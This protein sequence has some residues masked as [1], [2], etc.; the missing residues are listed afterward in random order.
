MPLKKIDENPTITDTVVFEITTPDA[1]GCLLA[2]PYKVESLVIY[3]V[4]RDFSSGNLSEY[5]NR[6][7]DAAK[8]KAAEDAEKKACADPTQANIDEAKRLRAESEASKFTNSFYFNEAKPVQVIGSKLFPAWLSTDTG[9][10]YITYVDKDANGVTQY[11]HFR[12][13]WQPKGVREG[14]YF[15]CW[16]WTPNP[17][18]DSLSAHLRFTLAGN[19][20]V[21]TSIPTHFTPPTKYETLLERYTPEM[22]K[23][24]MCHDDRTPD[25]L[26]KFNKSVAAGFTSLEDLA[27]QIVDLQD[28][29]SLHEALIPYLSNFFDLKLKTHDPTL[30]RRQ[31]KRAIPLFK[32]KGT[33]PALEEAMAQ[34]GLSLKKI[35]ML[36]QVVSPYTWQESFTFDTSYFFDLAKV[37]LP[38]DYLNFGLW[39]RMKGETDYISLSADYVNFT[40]SGGVTRMTWVGH[41]LSVQAIDLEKGDI[42]RVLYKYK[43][44]PSQTEQTIENYIRSLPLADIRDETAQ[45]Y[46]LKNWNVRL[47]EE[48]DPLFDLVIPNRHPYTDPLVFGK[49]RTEFPYSENV[50]NMDE[51]NGSIR[52]S[53]LPCDIGKE[54]LDPCGACMS[55]KFN[56]DVEIENLSNDRIKEAQEVIKEFVPFHAVLHTMN[57]TGSMNEFVQPPVEEIEML[58][59]YNGTDYAIV[60]E[61]QQ[62]FNRSMIL[63]LTSQQV[64]RNALATSEVAVATTTGTAYNDNIVVFSPDVN[65]DDIGLPTDG[66]GILEILP[67]SLIAGTTTLSNPKGHT[68]VV[69]AA[70]E[71]IA[72]CASTT[73]NN[74][75]FTFRVSNEVL[76]G[77]T[78]CNITQ[79]DLFTFSDPAVDFT[80]YA[81]KSEWDVARGTATAP[82]K[83]Q[84][85]AY[86]PTPYPIVHVL[87][88]GSLVLKNNGT[89]PTYAV[90]NVDYMLQN[91][92]GT[93]MKISE[94]GRLAVT[95]RAKTKA[96]SITMQD[97]AEAIEIGYYQVVGSSQYKV[98]GF[99]EGT[100]DS[101]Y[102]ADWTSGDSA[103]VAL[104]VYQRL[105]DNQVGY[106][107]HRGLKLRASGN[108]ES[109]LSIPN[110]KN[111][112]IPE[113]SITEN[114][115]FKENFLIVIDVTPD[116]DHVYFMAEI[117]GGNPPGF[118]T[119]TLDGP[120][121]YWKTLAAGGTTV[122]FTIYRY[123]KTANI[124][125]PGQQ[126]DL[127]A[128]TFKD[129]DRQGREIITKTITT[130]SSM[131]GGP[132]MGMA[133]V[134]EG[135]SIF[136]SIHQ[137]ESINYTIEYEDGSKEQGEI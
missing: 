54:F 93:Q 27:N 15:L 57:F 2:N 92:S 64:L 56:I 131:E 10:A 14:D 125:I 107:G 17:A 104:K 28:A 65:F 18:G 41:T 66:T 114:S 26:D 51:Y 22:F 43:D 103:G 89:L 117:D 88:N 13:E 123:V 85:V 106:L 37:A 95:R 67:P 47:I 16:T 130:S 100:N 126:Y 21:T 12:Y 73:A 23:M 38:V 98:I 24:L 111:S 121:T 68:A 82:W 96:L 137:E 86:S 1:N 109:S 29:N 79:D 127:P 25:V 118:T 35:T 122:T 20:Q 70:T 97:I 101:F 132:S 115:R 91:E 34:A 74:C 42:I 4:E 84:I 63:G 53:K 52:N 124:T 32:A 110:G 46:P 30:W 75:S 136:E 71:P 11:G 62:W 72:S 99:V 48:D 19:T 36:W 55:S 69:A 102:I 76:D 7:Y 59:A 80:Q 31:I 128:H 77:S 108:L 50:Y 113:S 105:V 49:V 8:L 3:Y 94:S 133:S 134:P 9:N 60:G 81:I 44:I 135:S 39:I 83:V 40:T 61:G 87:P 58:V 33:K 119:I 116:P 45:L 120:S 78:L 6:T 129:L 5:E 112:L 90:H